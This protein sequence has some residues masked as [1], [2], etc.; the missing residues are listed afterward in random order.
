MKLP[1]EGWKS[2]LPGHKLD[3]IATSRFGLWSTYFDTAKDSYC[4]A[5]KICLSFVPI[6][7][8]WNHAVL[9]YVFKSI[10]MSESHRNIKDLER[11]GAKIP[12]TILVYFSFI[13]NKIPGTMNTLDLMWFIPS[14][15][16]NIESRAYMVICPL[17]LCLHLP[18]SYRHTSGLLN[19]L[20]F[21]QSLCYYL[22]SF[23]KSHFVLLWKAS[24]LKI[25]IV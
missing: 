22:M 20:I 6:Y 2:V 21:I 23:Y 10:P 17:T 15:I 25:C 24:I 13:Q 12:S 5:F 8:S 1:K 18:Q 19:F 9:S 11:L 16:S 3:G 7:F 14:V 4:S